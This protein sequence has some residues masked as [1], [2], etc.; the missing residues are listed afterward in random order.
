MVLAMVALVVLGVK[1]MSRNKFVG[2]ML[3]VVA[4]EVAV[5]VLL[6]ELGLYAE[7]STLAQALYWTVWPILYFAMWRK[8]TPVVE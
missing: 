3:C 5:E 6:S 7:W 8:Y 4:C 2:V 1:M